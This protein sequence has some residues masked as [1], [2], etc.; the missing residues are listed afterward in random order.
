MERNLYLTFDSMKKAKKELK[1]AKGAQEAVS[2][3]AKA[4]PFVLI[5]PLIG[6]TEALSK[7]LQGLNNQY[8]EDRIA[9]IEEKYKSKKQNNNQ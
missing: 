4:A 9:Q 5:R 1:T 2:T 6:V 3:V 7:T 8:D